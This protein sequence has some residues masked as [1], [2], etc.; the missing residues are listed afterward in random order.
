M[1]AINPAEQHVSHPVAQADRMT[2][3]HR[4][5]LELMHLQAHASC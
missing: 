5:L 1:I 2:L 3:L 4:Q